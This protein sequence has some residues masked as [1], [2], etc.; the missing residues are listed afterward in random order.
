[1]KKLEKLNLLKGYVIH[2]PNKA[3]AIALCTIFDKMN[4]KWNTGEA[5]ITNSYW[6]YYK[7]E[8]CYIPY[9]QMYASLTYFKSDLGKK[10]IGH[11]YIIIPFDEFIK[12]FNIN[13]YE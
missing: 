3:D 9:K 1:M 10:Q 8:T 13:K 4:L 2:C 6:D 5:Y 7:N 12:K 11:K